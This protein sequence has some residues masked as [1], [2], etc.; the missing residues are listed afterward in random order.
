MTQCEGINF[1][2]LYQ[3]LAVGLTGKIIKCMYDNM[4]ACVKTKDGNT[5][6]FMCNI[7]LKQGCLA[8]PKLFSLFINEL[9][10]YLQNNGAS[11][12]QI[13]PGDDEI[14]SLMFADDVA[15]IADTVCG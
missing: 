5:D 9:V 12:I 8:S 1:G 3:P 2:I 6:S 10:K 4:T 15:L 7:G 13:Q 11:G 14:C